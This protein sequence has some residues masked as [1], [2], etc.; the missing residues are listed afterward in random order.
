MLSKQVGEIQP[1][2]IAFITMTY[3]ISFILSFIIILFFKVDLTYAQENYLFKTDDQ[4][5]HKR[6]I[7]KI[8]PVRCVNLVKKGIYG[9]G[10]LSVSDSGFFA[11]YDYE[12]NKI[13]SFD[14][15][16]DKTPEFYGAG[17]GRGPRQFLHPTALKVDNS[18]NIWLADANKITIT[19]WGYNGELL[20][21]YNSQPVFPFRLALTSKGFIAMAAHIVMSNRLFFY[22]KKDGN[23]DYSFQKPVNDVFAS[24]LYGGVIAAIDSILVYAGSHA[25]F[26]RA[27]N[28]KTGELIYSKSTIQPVMLAGIIEKKMSKNT[29][30]TTINREESVFASRD[31]D[32]SNSKIYSLFSGERKTI[33][34]KYIDIYQLVS[35]NYLKS[36]QINRYAKSMSVANNNL[37]TIEVSQDRKNIYLCQY[38]LQSY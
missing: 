3:K 21:T 28:V 29:Y 13:V 25:G 1:V 23:L 9:P 7:T 12:L 31:M 37:Y 16:N 30:F 27:Y 8:K 34:G 38:N 22:F 15:F 32:I 26:I 19:K 11:M 35:G 33:R 24:M 4:K 17:E 20:K 18:N 10:K 6:S 2:L 5:V 14:S 36:F